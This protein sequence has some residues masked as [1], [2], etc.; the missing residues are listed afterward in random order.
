MQA[1]TRMAAGCLEAELEAQ[2]LHATHSS[3]SARHA[4]LF[5]CT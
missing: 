2:T 3:L 5:R 1:L 4:A